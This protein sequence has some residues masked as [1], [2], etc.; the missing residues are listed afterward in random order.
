MNTLNLGDKV[1]RNL[2][3]RMGWLGSSLGLRPKTVPREGRTRR[4]PQTL[5]SSA[6]S[7]G[8]S[9][10]KTHQKLR[11][12]RIVVS[13]GRGLILIVVFHARWVFEGPIN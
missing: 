3:F 11:I 13:R 12:I 9:V 4:S 2:T 7:A 5:Y 1:D 6:L 8:T 10:K